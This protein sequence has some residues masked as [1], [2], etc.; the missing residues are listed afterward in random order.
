MHSSY[1]SQ[2]PNR[3]RRLE[4]HYSA[5]SPPVNLSRIAQE[6][7][8]IFLWAYRTANNGVILW[9]DGTVE[10][11]PAAIVDVL[12]TLE[13]HSSYDAYALWLWLLRQLSLRAITICMHP[14]DASPS[15]PRD[16]GSAVDVFV[17]ERPSSCSSCCSRT[18]LGP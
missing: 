18:T 3:L 15:L 6:Y 2:G 4:V 5:Y 13:I 12:E 10:S 17:T 14:L 1:S 11:V 7:P 9:P 16:R 8:I